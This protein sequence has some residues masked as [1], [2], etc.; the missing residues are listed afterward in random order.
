MLEDSPNPRDIA[1]PWYTGDFDT[2]C[3]DIQE[4]CEIWLKKLEALI[5]K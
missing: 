2:A 1:D 5:T 4:G 3:W